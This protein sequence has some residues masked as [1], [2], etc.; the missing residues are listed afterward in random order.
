MGRDESTANTDREFPQR[1]ASCDGPTR[2]LELSEPGQGAANIALRQDVPPNGGYGWVCTG[3]V[4]MIN[5]HTWGINS[6]I[7]LKSSRVSKLTAT[8][9]GDLLVTLS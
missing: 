6:V 4:F 5:A 9:M 7:Q 3:C 8:G 1:S 2:A